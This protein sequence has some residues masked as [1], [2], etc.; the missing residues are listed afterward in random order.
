MGAQKGGTKIESKGKKPKRTS[1]RARSIHIIKAGRPLGSF[2]RGAGPGHFWQT[3]KEEC[4][5]GSAIILSLAGN[6]LSIDSHKSLLIK[7]FV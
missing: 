4:I 3:I 6:K 5:V 7:S 1:Q 2:V